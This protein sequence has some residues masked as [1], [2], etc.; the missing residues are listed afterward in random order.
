MADSPVKGDWRPASPLVGL[1]G[2]DVPLAVV[3][4]V[5]SRTGVAFANGHLGS[6][7]IP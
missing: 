4:W 3:G 6:R 2:E 1:S 7:R 5:T